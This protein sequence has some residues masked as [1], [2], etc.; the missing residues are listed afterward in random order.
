MLFPSHKTV[1]QAISELKIKGLLFIQFGRVNQRI[2]HKDKM[3][4]YKIKNFFPLLSLHLLYQ[5]SKVIL[6]IS[7]LKKKYYKNEQLIIKKISCIKN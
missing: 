7:R 4:K 5:I 3:Q 6:Q 1:I 2:Y